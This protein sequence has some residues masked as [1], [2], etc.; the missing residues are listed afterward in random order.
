[1]D[2]LCGPNYREKE[3][4]ALGEDVNRGRQRGQR[5]NKIKMEEWKLRHKCD[6]GRVAEG[7]KWPIREQAISSTDE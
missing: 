7:S 5:K 6:K 1:M 4:G 2:Q 3:V